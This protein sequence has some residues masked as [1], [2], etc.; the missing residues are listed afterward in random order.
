MLNYFFV[1]LRLKALG[2]LGGFLMEYENFI[3]RVACVVQM[4]APSQIY[5]F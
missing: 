4:G 1:D 5:M 2:G 3:K